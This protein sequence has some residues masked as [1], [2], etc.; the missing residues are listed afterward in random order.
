MTSLFNLP[1]VISPLN[2]GLAIG[3]SGDSPGLLHAALDPAAADEQFIDFA[4]TWQDQLE[5]VEKAVSMADWIARKK[6]SGL[7]PPRKR[8]ARE[9]TTNWCRPRPP[10]RA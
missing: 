5:A 1:L 8:T 9:Y 6:A 3:F 2:A 7:M 10:R 4:G